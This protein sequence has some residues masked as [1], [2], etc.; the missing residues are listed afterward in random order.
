MW[1]WVIWGILTV[2]FGAVYVWV[3]HE[4]TKDHEE[5]KV[6]KVPLVKDGD[7][8]RTEIP[9]SDDDV[10]AALILMEALRREAE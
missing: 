6:I 9:P 7:V 1:N 8:W 4:L 10:I 3:I 5:E 2:A